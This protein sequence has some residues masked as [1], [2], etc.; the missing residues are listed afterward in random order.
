MSLNSYQSNVRF[1]IRVV[2]TLCALVVCSYQVYIVSILYYRYPT[3]VDI[4]LDPSSFV[5]IPG[6]TICSELSSTILVEEL[7]KIQPSLYTTF[8]GKTRTQIALLLKKR[9]MREM[10]L[11]SLHSLPINQQHLLTVSSDKFFKQCELPTPLGQY[12][13]N[14]ETDH[15][16]INFPQFYHSW[17]S[18]S[19]E[20]INCTSISPIVETISFEFKC[21]T[22]FNQA[23]D[24]DLDINYQIPR[25]VATNLKYLAW[26]QLNRDF[27]FN[28]L[29]YIHSP[30]SNVL[31]V[32]L[33]PL[34]TCLF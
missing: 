23:D 24:N 27:M 13:Q 14:K 15:E 5:T 8:A 6:L 3:N 26:I 21:F 12:I 34:F 18:R 20:K 17:N 7:V 22:L 28:G 9:E 2:V 25:D 16:T 33:S 29:L 4:R 11:K 31:K 10:L 30:E 19:Y 32:P 1:T